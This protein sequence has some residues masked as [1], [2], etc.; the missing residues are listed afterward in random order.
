MVRML[1]SRP[2][3]AS[4]VRKPEALRMYGTLAVSGGRLGALPG[5]EQHALDLDPGACGDRFHGGLP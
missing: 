1:A 3:S 4:A 5:L 2:S